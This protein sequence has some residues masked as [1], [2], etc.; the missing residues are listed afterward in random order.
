MGQATWEYRE[1]AFPAQTSREIARLSLTATAEIHHWELDRTRI[2]R[3]GRRVV[4]LRRRIYR[5]RR[6]EETPQ[7]HPHQI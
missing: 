3:D 4:R 2:Y 7:A 1:V 5:F 6:S